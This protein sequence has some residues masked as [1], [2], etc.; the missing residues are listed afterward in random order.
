VFALEQQPEMN[1]F[2]KNVGSPHINFDNRFDFGYCL[3]ANI[4]FAP[5]FVRHILL[6]LPPSFG[7]APGKLINQSCALPNQSRAR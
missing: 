1:Q 4:R 2:S 5:T 6:Y 7:Y 3:R